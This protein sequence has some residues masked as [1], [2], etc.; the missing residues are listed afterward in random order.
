MHGAGRYTGSDGKL[1]FQDLPFM[2]VPLVVSGGTFLVHR[3]RPLR[4]AD[5]LLFVVD[6]PCAVA[7]RPPASIAAS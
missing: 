7:L 2:L 6:R 5:R 4:C 3:H 1:L